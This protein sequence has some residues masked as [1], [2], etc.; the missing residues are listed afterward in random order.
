V[1]A[2]PQNTIRTIAKIM[3]IPTSKAISKSK[4]GPLNELKRRKKKRKR[5]RQERKKSS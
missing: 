2:R 1:E 4:K 3:T 5:K